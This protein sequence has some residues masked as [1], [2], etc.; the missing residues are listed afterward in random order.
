MPNAVPAHRERLLPIGKKCIDIAR[1]QKQ[2]D[3]VRGGN[4]PEAE[5]REKPIWN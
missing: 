5:G 1:G 2:Y 3:P 4:N